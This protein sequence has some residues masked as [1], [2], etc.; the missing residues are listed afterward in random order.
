[1]QCVSLDKLLTSL[2]FNSFNC[3]DG[4]NNRYFIRSLKEFSVKCPTQGV[5]DWVS[6]EADSE[7][8][9][10]HI[11]LENVPGINICGREG[12]KAREGQMT[13]Q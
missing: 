9:A 7:F 8:S 4:K 3:Y 6:L 10:Q 13:A 2:S 5:V 1:M 12:K 11:L